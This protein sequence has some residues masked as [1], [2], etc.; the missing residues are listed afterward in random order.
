MFILRAL[1][2]FVWTFF[3]KLESSEIRASHACAARLFIP[4]HLQ[5]IEFPQRAIQIKLEDFKAKQGDT[6]GVDT[7]A[8]VTSAAQVRMLRQL[9]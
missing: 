3:I 8:L 2:S 7:D 9:A 1:L 4:F 6:T 5:A